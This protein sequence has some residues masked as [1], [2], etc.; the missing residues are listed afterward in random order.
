MKFVLTS[1]HES[2]NY[3][4]RTEVRLFVS[5]ERDRVEG[6][7]HVFEV[8]MKRRHLKGTGELEERVNENLR[9]WRTGRTE[10][11]EEDF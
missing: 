5:L 1:T 7:L 11:G 2:I 6:H 4:A 9:N 10:Y 8:S 3:T